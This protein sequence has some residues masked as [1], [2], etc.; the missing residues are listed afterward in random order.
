MALRHHPPTFSRPRRVEADV[1]DEGEF[2]AALTRSGVIDIRL[3]EG[4]KRQR[5]G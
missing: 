1:F 5:E 4:L 2:F 3:L